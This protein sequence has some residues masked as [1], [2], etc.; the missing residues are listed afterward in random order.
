MP[1]STRNNKETPLLF[2][3]DTASLERSIRKGIRS[4]TIDN[5]TRQPPLTH[6]GVKTGHDGINA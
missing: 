3:S 1:R 6:V 2:S 4:S 5:N